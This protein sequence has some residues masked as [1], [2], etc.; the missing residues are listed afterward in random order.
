MTTRVLYTVDTAA[1][2]LSMG[3]DSVRAAIA[4]GRL[5]ASQF[6]HKIRISADAIREFAERMEADHPA[7]ISPAAAAKAAETPAA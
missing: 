7:K 6:D 5:R 4:D 2:Q 1:E 3:K